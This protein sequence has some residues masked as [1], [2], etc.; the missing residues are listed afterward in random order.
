MITQLTIVVN[1]YL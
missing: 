1:I